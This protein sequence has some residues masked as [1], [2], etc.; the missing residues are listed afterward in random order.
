MYLPSHCLQWLRSL[1]LLSHTLNFSI[2]PVVYQAID[3]SRGQLSDMP[4][5]LKDIISVRDPTYSRYSQCLSGRNP[6]QN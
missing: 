5:G 1:R 6:D 2:T 3:L 4:L